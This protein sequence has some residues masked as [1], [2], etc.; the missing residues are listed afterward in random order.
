[1][2]FEIVETSQLPPRRGAKYGALKDALKALPVG[3]VMK[4][5]LDTPLERKNV[6]ASISLWAAQFDCLF[7]SRVSQEDHTVIYVWKLEAIRNGQ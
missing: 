2:E 7:S 4:V 6:T 1:M 3:K 5:K